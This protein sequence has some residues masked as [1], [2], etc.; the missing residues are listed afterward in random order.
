MQD[1]CCTHAAHH[2]TDALAKLHD[3]ATTCPMYAHA[4]HVISV[5]LP[6]NGKAPIHAITA[7]ACFLRLFVFETLQ[8][9]QST[10]FAFMGKKALT[11]AAISA[12]VA[13][14]LLLLILQRPCQSFIPEWLSTRVVVNPCGWAMAQPGHGVPGSQQ[15]S[16][17]LA[18]AKSDASTVMTWHGWLEGASVPGGLIGAP[19]NFTLSAEE[20]L[21]DFSLVS[22]LLIITGGPQ[23]L[24]R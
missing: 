17:L 9:C 1:G 4:K 14:V 2:H 6:C 22:A 19:E 23:P 15:T 3:M 13:A 20:V 8:S 5:D 18:S 16:S 24:K 7:A 10:F 21:R 12:S 11:C